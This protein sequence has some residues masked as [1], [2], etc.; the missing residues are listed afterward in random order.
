MRSVM[1]FAIVTLWSVSNFLPSVAAQAKSGQPAKPGQTAQPG[2]PAAA[3]PGKAVTPQFNGGITQNPWFVDPSIGKQLTLTDQQMKRLHDAY[4]QS[5]TDY[6][7]SLQTLNNLSPQ[8]REERLRQL[9]STFDQ[10]TMKAAQ[11][12]LNQQQFQRYQQLNRQWRWWDALNDPTTANMLR[13]TQQQRDQLN[14]LWRSYD[15]SM[16]TIY[17][18]FPNNQDQA[19]K[20]WNDLRTQTMQKMNQILTPQQQQTWQQMT[21]Q[22]FNFQTVPG[23]TTTAPQTNK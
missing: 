5:W 9:N 8:Q 19:N 17:M 22:S 23:V 10:N 12:A 7:K 20:S 13:L 3:Q 1:V 6:N 11:D 4:N 2:Q 18:N 16:G 15:Q 21:G 14:S